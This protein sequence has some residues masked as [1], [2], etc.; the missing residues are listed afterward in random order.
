MQTYQYKNDKEWGQIPNDSYTAE[1]F[2]AIR[3]Y[4]LANKGTCDVDDITW[5]DVDMD[6][7]FARIN[8]T[9]SSMGEEYLYKM[10]RMPEYDEGNLKDEMDYISTLEDCNPEI[11]NYEKLINILEDWI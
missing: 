8:S 7:V 6:N 1:K 9:Y 11:M 5:N 10:L 2:A 3:E 4:Y